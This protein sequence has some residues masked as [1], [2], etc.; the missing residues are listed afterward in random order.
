MK[1]GKKAPRF[2]F[3]RLCTKL[4][5]AV[6]AEVGECTR[7][8]AARPCVQLLLLTARG[9]SSGTMLAAADTISTMA[10]KHLK[11]T[12][13]KYVSLKGAQHPRVS[14][15]RERQTE[16]GWRAATGMTSTSSQPRAPLGE[17]DEPAGLP[18]DG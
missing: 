7:V 8:R 10:M 18:R 14:S 3:A 17:A 9:S 5:E 4:E 6:P 11:Q 15:H 16:A 2:P 12:D 1:E 13:L